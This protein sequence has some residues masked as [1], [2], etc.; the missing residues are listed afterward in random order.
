M[1]KLTVM[2]VACL[3]TIGS[4]FADVFAGAEKMIENFMAK[5]TYIKV[6]SDSDNCTY[7]N[8]D[9]VSFI[10]IDEDDMKIFT[11]K[12]NLFYFYNLVKVTGGNVA[13]FDLSSFDITSDDNC[14]II[15][16][17]KSKKSKKN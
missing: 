9:Y 4:C 6:V 12:T 5:G 3:L 14:N 2:V 15:I 16:T 17:V 8:K 10:A 1:K 11:P 13:Q 7:V